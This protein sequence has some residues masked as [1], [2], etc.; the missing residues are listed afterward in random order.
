LEAAHSLLRLAMPGLESDLWAVTVERLSD[1]VA[2]CGFTP[3][4]MV[5]SLMDAGDPQRLVVPDAKITCGAVVSLAVSGW[6][7]E[8]LPDPVCDFVAAH[9]SHGMQLMA[10]AV[11][12]VFHRP[13]IQQGIQ[14]AQPPQQRLDI[15]TSSEEFYQQ[16]QGLMQGWDAQTRQ[17]FLSWFPDHMLMYAPKTLGTLLYGAPKRGSPVMDEAMVEPFLHMAEHIRYDAKSKS[18]CTRMLRSLPA[19]DA[20][21]ALVW[22]RPANRATPIVIEQMCAMHPDLQ[23]EVSRILTGLDVT[24]SGR[25]DAMARVV[26]PVGY[27]LIEALEPLAS[28]TGVGNAYDRTTQQARHAIATAVVPFL[29][30]ASRQVLVDQATQRLINGTQTNAAAA[31]LAALADH[32]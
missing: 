7:D 11:V 29:G 31:A 16:H 2:A 23:Q 22:S 1:A 17:R 28:R 32:R 19:T 26:S 21:H 9:A 5:E 27:D 25:D 6:P 18:V 20:V 8:P 3:R 14:R 4:S 30:P 12:S 13:E 10:H 24:A 15:R